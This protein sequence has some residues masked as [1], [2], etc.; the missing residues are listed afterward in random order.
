METDSMLLV[1]E[2]EADLA[3]L[4]SATPNWVHNLRIVWNHRKLLMRVVLV[5]FF[6]NLIVVMLI[7]K[8]YVSQ[9]RIMPPENGSSNSALLAALAGRSLDGGLL[10]GL[11]A[12]LM[13]GHNTGAL[14]IDL[15][16]SSSATGKVID[17]F[18][19]QHVYRKRYRVDAAKVLARRTSI[20][21]DKK[22]GVITISV[23]D[24]D[25]V[26][27]R[28][29]VLAY[30]NELNAVVTRTNNSSAH[31]E[32]LFIEARLGSV[33]AHLERAQQAMSEF[34]S[35]HST[36]DLPE[37]T[38]VTVQSEGRVEGELIMA[39]GELGSLQQVYG[40]AN[41]RV[42]A[43]EVRVAML[44]RELE[45]MGGS[46][47]PLQDFPKGQ[48]G[49]VQG[50]IRG[51]QEPYLPLRQV[52]R[53]A[54]PYADL[55]REVRV[56][57]TVYDL[58]TQQYEIARIQEAKDVPAVNVIDAPGVPEKKS[59]PPRAVLTLSLT[60]LTLLLS[61]AFLIAREHWRGVDPADSRSTLAREV[62]HSITGAIN[63]CVGLLRRAA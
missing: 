36:I 52:P 59:F 13:G 56:Q 26:R 45:K 12:S 15:L 44:K 28:D 14:F 54:V 33:K 30:L 50:S 10:G 18:Q 6:V 31:Q 23:T 24:H 17:Q 38:R 53:L 3:L 47:A 41:V 63:R 46:A 35:T 58:L 55:Y 16:Q 5:A 34:A 9:A 39:Q 21:Q 8:S 48:S 11:A 20:A 7:P 51:G 40:D 22:S 25:P 62:A 37:Q 19:L 57:E 29:M 27:A 32:R 61:S 2:R 43:A 49:E 4:Q 1:A 42:R 60:L